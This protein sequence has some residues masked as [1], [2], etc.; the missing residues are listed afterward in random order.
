[1]Q[2]TAQAKAMK[3]RIRSVEGENEWL[4]GMLRIMKQSA[5]AGG[6]HVSRL[7]AGARKAGVGAADSAP[8]IIDRTPGTA[9]LPD[10]TNP[11]E[12]R[13]AKIQT[14]RRK[15]SPVGRAMR[16]SPI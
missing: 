10:A 5:F 4:K 16:D 3:H 11:S 15:G 7:D 6:E 12:S 13:D 8:G 14:A 9:P 1:M 2:E